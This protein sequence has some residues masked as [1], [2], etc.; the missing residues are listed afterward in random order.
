MNKVGLILIRTSEIMDIKKIK[1]QSKW[2][3]FQLNKI[4][5]KH[6][7]SIYIIQGFTKD[8]KG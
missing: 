7:Q 1:S 4:T 8:T 2:D 6:L 5:S 3:A